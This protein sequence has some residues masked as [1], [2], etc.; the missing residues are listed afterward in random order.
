MLRQ[1]VCI[2]L[3]GVAA[4]QPRE[5]SSSVSVVDLVKEFDRAERRPPES[6]VL[7]EQRLDGISRPSIIG[8]APGRLIW[9]LPLPSRGVFRAH[10]ALETSTRARVR[11][12]ISDARIYEDLAQIPL[13]GTSRSWSELRADLS[14]YAGW[15]LSLFYRPNRIRW[16]LVLSADA[17]EGVSGRV[18]WGAPEIL[19]DREAAREYAARRATQP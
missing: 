9:T 11:V 12:G 18:T 17:I 14:R 19:T 2:L 1:R 5:K 7:R 16:R 13:T 10:V 4:C 15:K 3:L 8:P 6:Y